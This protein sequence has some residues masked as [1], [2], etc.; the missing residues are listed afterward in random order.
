VRR[1]SLES[2]TSTANWFLTE[3][4]EKLFYRFSLKG[5]EEPKQ[6]DFRHVFFSICNFEDEPLSKRQARLLARLYRSGYVEYANK[7]EDLIASLPEEYK[8]VLGT[9]NR[10]AKEE[11]VSNEEV[12]RL[13]RLFK[14]RRKGTFK[15][16][17]ENYESDKEYKELETVF[18]LL[19]TARTRSDKVIAIDAVMTLVHD[20]GSALVVWLKGMPDYDEGSVQNKTN[21]V[22]N[23]LAEEAK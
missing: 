19:D 18:N 2:F 3:K 4:G 14:R 12:D 21:T 15:R 8:Y 16:L 22:L 20:C 1:P 6:E 17:V 10:I 9:Y 5:Y 11:H 7:V 23:R 13:F